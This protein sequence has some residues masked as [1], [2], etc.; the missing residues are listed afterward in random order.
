M[1]TGYIT[2]VDK[3]FL[4]GHRQS[5]EMGL[6]EASMYAGMLVKIG[7]TNNDVKINDGATLGYG[8]LGY[9][10]TP[11][12]YRPANIDAPY[13]INAR[14]GIV[15]GTGAILRAILANG[16]NVVSGDKLVG[17]AGGALK[18]WVPVVDTAGAGTTEEMIEAMA[19]EDGTTT[20]SAIKLIVRSLI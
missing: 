8:W 15:H 6:E 13:A 11:L 2:P 10:D 18:K 17:T 5:V 7:T 9:E 16:T 20:G 12:M 1:D 19:M 3:I 4:S 14:A